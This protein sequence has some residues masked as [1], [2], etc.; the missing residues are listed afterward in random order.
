MYCEGFSTPY[1]RR[2]LTR[3]PSYLLLGRLCI[4]NDILPARCFSDGSHVH[5]LLLLCGPLVNPVCVL[6]W[7]V[8]LRYKGCE[9]LGLPV[10]FS[11]QNEVFEGDGDS[12]LHMSS[13]YTRFRASRALSS[14]WFDGGCG[15]YVWVVRDCL[16]VYV[17]RY[18]SV[19]WFSNGG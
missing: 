1:P 15:M 12:A 14:S 2:C 6:E 3:W 4:A 10:Q 5:S 7:A 16:P 13:R 11:D 17:A 8:A 19:Y 9:D 18:L